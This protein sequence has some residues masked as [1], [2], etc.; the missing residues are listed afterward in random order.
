MSVVVGDCDSNWIGNERSIVS[1]AFLARIIRS[2]V[3]KLL[4]IGVCRLWLCRI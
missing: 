1:R 4:G 3:P 2:S